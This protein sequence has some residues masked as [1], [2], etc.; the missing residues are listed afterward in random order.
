MSKKEENNE[1]KKNRLKSPPPKR[2]GRSEESPLSSSAA[3]TSNERQAAAARGAALPRGVLGVD[4]PAHAAKPR[5]DVF[6]SQKGLVFLSLCLKKRR[7]DIETW[8]RVVAGWTRSPRAPP[9][10]WSAPS[11]RRRAASGRTSSSRRRACSGVLRLNFYRYRVRNRPLGVLRVVLVFGR[12][13]TMECGLESLRRPLDEYV[14]TY[15]IA[16]IE[17]SG[18][19][20]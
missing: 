10:S 2:A 17:V 11:T 5:V 4:H 18:N 8:V 20:P 14:G 1:T 6:S 7:R 19:V 16:R 12:E 3:A 9:T 13:G 15:R